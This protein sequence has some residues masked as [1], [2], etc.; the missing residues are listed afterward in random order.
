MTAISLIC[1]SNAASRW[2]CFWIGLRWGLGHSLGLVIIAAVVLGAAHALDLETEGLVADNIVGAMM[3]LLGLFGLFNGIRW[4]RSG[5]PGKKDTTAAA[6][7]AGGTS[8]HHGHHGHGADG[9]VTTGEWDR[10]DAA[11]AAAAAASSAAA[12]AET[13][14]A[15][16][17]ASEPLYE[18]STAGSAAPASVSAETERADGGGA[19]KNESESES[20]DA[21]DRRGAGPQA[22]QQEECASSVV[23]IG[24]DGREADSALEDVTVELSSSHLPSALTSPTTAIGGAAAG[25]GGCGG[26]AQAAAKWASTRWATSPKAADSGPRSASGA[27]LAR[28]WVQ[29]LIS[30]IVGLVHGISGPGGVL[31]VLPAVALNV[32]Y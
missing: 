17:A 28:P 32:R 10:P 9:S 24:E 22:A 1:A 4:W 12:H 7:S 16:D 27:Y 13:A 18:C 19:G 20:G 2:R 5:A 14:E 21:K 3:V 23:M 25:G 8:L 29:R 6:D 15:A 26:Q 30:L 11:E 31:G